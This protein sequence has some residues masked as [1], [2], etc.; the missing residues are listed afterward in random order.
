M[1]MRGTLD[2]LETLATQIEAESLADE[3]LNEA[4][5]Y[6]QDRLGVE[7]GDFAA[8]FFS[9]EFEDVIKRVLVKYIE[10]EQGQMMADEQM[11]DE[12]LDDTAN[13]RESFGGAMTSFK[14]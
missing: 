1:D 14:P 2:L 4:V 3:A 9:G 10:Q 13:T 5:R 8:Q 11:L 7:T 6:I 12:Y